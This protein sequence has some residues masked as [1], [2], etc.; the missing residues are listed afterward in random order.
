MESTFGVSAGIWK[1]VQDCSTMEM[2]LMRY[3]HVIARW[4]G[5]KLYSFEELQSIM[6]GASYERR[7]EK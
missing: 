6:L 5:E 3:G 7:G 2:S 1:L 4:Q